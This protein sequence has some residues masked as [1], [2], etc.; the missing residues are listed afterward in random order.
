MPDLKEAYIMDKEKNT[1][2]PLVDLIEVKPMQDGYRWVAITAMLFAIG[3]I[4]HTV[5]PNVGGVT[6]NWTIAMYS[7]VINLTNPTLSQAVGIGFIAGIT[8][9]PSSKSAFPL[10]NIASEL[11]AITC[12]ILVRRCC[13]AVWASG[14]CAP[15]DGILATMVSGGVFTFILKIVLGLPLHVWL[16]AMLPVVAIVAR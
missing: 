3:I 14:S 13:A 12:C 1:R 9:V 16:Y 8:L 11:G 15:G 5:S 2:L 10:G 4:L 6:P 7:I